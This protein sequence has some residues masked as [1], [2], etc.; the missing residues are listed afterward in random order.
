MKLLR[1]IKG[2]DYAIRYLENSQIGATKLIR[3][4]KDEKIEVRFDKP[5]PELTDDELAEARNVTRKHILEKYYLSCFRRY[6]KGD[7]KKQDLWE[8]YTEP[9]WGFA[10]LYEVGLFTKVLLI[11]SDRICLSRGKWPCFGSN[12]IPEGRSSRRF[13]LP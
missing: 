2:E 1:F 10:L 11:S 7:E 3:H 9:S 13:C 4:E 8:S 6:A 12:T 5:H